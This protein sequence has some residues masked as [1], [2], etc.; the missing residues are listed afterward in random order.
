MPRPAPKQ[1]YRDV[2][3][4]QEGD[5]GDIWFIC[6]MERDFVIICPEDEPW[7]HA[8]SE[9]YYRRFMADAGPEDIWPPDGF[10]YLTPE[11]LLA[12]RPGISA[13]MV[14]GQTGD[15]HIPL[16]A[17]AA[18]AGISLDHHIPGEKSGRARGEIPKGV[19][20]VILFTTHISP[21]AKEKFSTAARRAGV[22]FVRTSSKGFEQQL[23]SFME[24]ARDRFGATGGIDPPECW[25]ELGTTGWVLEG[26][27]C[28]GDGAVPSSNGVAPSPDGF[29]GDCLVALGLISIGFINARWGA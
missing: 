8:R 17:K 20:L 7:N 11:E 10:V 3:G 22:P 6:N 26:P 12:P 18:R 13:L 2:L 19:Q 24:R 23:L 5:P 25:W 28:V 14:G 21:V 1:R 29:C 4:N 27:T 9:V 15:K 16:V